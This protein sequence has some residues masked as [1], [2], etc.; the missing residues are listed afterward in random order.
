MVGS[1]EAVVNLPLDWGDPSTRGAFTEQVGQLGDVDGD[2]LAPSRVGR[3]A[4]DRCP[5][6][7]PARLGA[8]ASYDK[9]SAFILEHGGN[10]A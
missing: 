1:A 2:A 5:G 3:F 8:V 7:F 6:S 9:A 4:V 10:T